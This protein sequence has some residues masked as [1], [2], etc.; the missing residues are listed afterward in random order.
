M[1]KILISLSTLAVILALAAHCLVASED[2]LAGVTVKNFKKPDYNEKTGKLNYIIYGENAK[3]VG[4]LVKM[5]KVKIDFMEPDEK[6]IKGVITS[7][8]ADYDRAAKLIRGDREVLYSSPAVEAQGMGFDADQARQI[9]H[10]RKDVRVTIRST[11]PIFQKKGTP[12]G[13][14]TAAN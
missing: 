6:T 1:M 2:E 8:E 13:T 7:P 11:D 9:V 4:T 14:G 5:E 3:T 10:I 12:A